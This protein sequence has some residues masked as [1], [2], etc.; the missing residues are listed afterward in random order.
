M[1][2]SQH[3]FQDP[4]RKF[5][6]KKTSITLTAC[7]VLTACATLPQPLSQG[8]SPGKQRILALAEHEWIYFGRQTVVLDGDQESIPHVG[9][10]EDD[11]TRAHRVNQYWRAV[12]RPAVTGYDCQEPWSAAF[13]SWIMARAGIPEEQFAPAD[14][15]WVYLNRLIRN[16][17][18]GRIFVPH[19]LA[20]YRPRPGDLVCANRDSTE[21]FPEPGK[22]PSE[23]PENTRLH[24]DIVVAQKG[25]TLEAIGGNVRNSVSKTVMELDKRGFLH[26]M[27]KRRWFLVVENRA[28]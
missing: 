13:V 10:W 22:P 14:A 23:I 9:L 4:P 28:E 15:H 27:P 6:M 8:L 19:P 3:V 26:S 20:D 5:P 18:P 24:C 12:A 16:A 17:A 7:L 25:R 1:K 2:C 21:L 11:E